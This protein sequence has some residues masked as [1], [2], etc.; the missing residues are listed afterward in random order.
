MKNYFKES[1]CH[2]FAFMKKVFIYV[3]VFGFLLIFYG[4]PIPWTPYECD[5]EYPVNIKNLKDTIKT[6]D[7]LWVENDF[8]PGFCLEQGTANN[9]RLTESPL[10]YKWI[11]DTIVFCKN[12]IVNHDVKIAS[13]GYPYYD[14]EVRKQNG[15]YQSKYGIVF[16]DTGIYVLSTYLGG[17][18]AKGTD[19]NF[20]PYFNTPSNNIYLIPEKLQGM[21]SHYSEKPYYYMTYFFVVVE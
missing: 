14:I 7:T 8:D 12:A 10:I 13:N 17:I 19:I 6:T 3:T 11:N 20:I 9:G 18:A 5:Y 21:Y 4:C 1:T 2:A 15:R 16:P